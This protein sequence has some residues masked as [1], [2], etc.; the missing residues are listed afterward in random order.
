MTFGGQDGRTPVGIRQRIGIVERQ[1]GG[2]P[3]ILDAEDVFPTERV[4]AYDIA[5]LRLAVND[6][7]GVIGYPAKTALQLVR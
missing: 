4:A 2:L 5:T 6:D 3:G 1:W 7:R